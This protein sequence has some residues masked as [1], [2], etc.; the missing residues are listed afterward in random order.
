MEGVATYHDL[1]G[2][3]VEPFMVS[4]LQVHVS[5]KIGEARVRGQRAADEPGRV[6]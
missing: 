6:K 4:R 5:E 2:G 1:K 3:M